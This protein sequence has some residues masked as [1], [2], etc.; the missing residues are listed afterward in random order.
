MSEDVT[1]SWLTDTLRLARRLPTEV[2]PGI[3]ADR[4][5][6]V[7]GWSE[8]SGNDAPWIVFDG[9]SAVGKDTQIDLIT[10]WLESSGLT[11]RLVGG[12]GDGTTLGPLTGTL[13]TR[14]A[15]LPGASRWVADYRIKAA[16]WGSLR[17]HEPAPRK[18]D[19]VLSNRGP[20][21]QLVYSAVSGRLDLL[22]DRDA[23]ATADAA[24]RANDLHLLLSCPD[25]D[26]VERARRRTV[27]GEKSPRDVDT[28]R[29][30]SAANRSFHEL[31]ARLPWVRT[32]ETTGDREANFASVKRVII[33]AV[34]LGLGEFERT[35][36]DGDAA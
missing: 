8:A 26:V 32:V 12:T 31:A 27:A 16:A 20:L 33:N 7:L 10:E 24:V 35:E 17:G 14:N 29:F 21:S 19:I 18:A 5:R 34:D 15:A 22:A 36:R 6:S 30:V 11:V 9:P 23:L 2:A 3:L 4:F 28:P 1:E 25:A 13:I